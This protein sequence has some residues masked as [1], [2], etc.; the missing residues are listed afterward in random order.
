MKQPRRPSSPRK[1][2]HSKQPPIPQQFWDYVAEIYDL[3]QADWQLQLL[4]VPSPD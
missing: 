4:G 3:H 2:K 1:S